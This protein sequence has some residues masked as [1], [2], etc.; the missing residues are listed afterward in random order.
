LL[1]IAVLV[2]LA[3]AALLILQHEFSRSSEKTDIITN[4]NYFSNDTQSAFYRGIPIPGA[5]PATFIAL[6]D[7][8]GRHTLFSKDARHVY[9][10]DPQSGTTDILLGADPDTFRVLISLTVPCIPENQSCDGDFPFAVILAKD[11]RAVY[12]ARGGIIEGADPFSFETLQT[13]DGAPSVFAQDKNRIYA[14]SIKGDAT[15][16]TTDRKSFHIISE[17]EAQDNNHFFFEDSAIFS[18]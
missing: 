3:C 16:M 9:I 18:R 1:T 6:N 4:D 12:G 8:Y 13:P 14:G 2:G 15:H 5:D 7:P 11:N 17:T 10:S